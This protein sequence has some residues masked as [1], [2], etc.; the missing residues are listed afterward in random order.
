MRSGLTFAKHGRTESKTKMKKS[1]PLLIITAAVLW[2]S[3][4]LFIRT[5]TAL[6]YETF[7]LVF[8]RAVLTSLSLIAYFLIFD[9]E[10]LKIKLKDFPIFLLTSLVSVILF[11]FCYMNAINSGSISIAA[12]LLYT[13]PIFV[14]VISA[15]LFKEKITPLKTAALILAFT[16]C[17]LVSGV[18]GSAGSLSP[19]ALL[20]GIASGLTYGMYSI[21]TKIG[22]KKYSPLTFTVY[23]FLISSVISAFICKPAEFVSTTV[24]KP[25]N[26][27]ILVLFSLA[28]NVIPYI[29]F[30]SGLKYMDAG[31]ANI[32]ATIE[33]VVATLLGI[34][35]LHEKLN[36]VSALGIFLVLFS[37]VILNVP[38]KKH[39]SKY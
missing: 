2:G 25:S 14:T 10:K 37:A 6:G 12:T 24:Q 16:G 35:V 31:K 5:L 32:T 27:I 15:F 7:Q 4:G 9:R 28:T 1:A 23:T 33:P 20:F 21:F 22:I 30:T 39:T 36:A 26:I 29:C 38:H 18:I 8:C 3:M 19:A 17:V 13:A 11:N 34:F